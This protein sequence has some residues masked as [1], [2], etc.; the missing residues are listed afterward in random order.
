[1]GISAISAQRPQ[2]SMGQNPAVDSKIQA[3]E[4]KRDE[5]KKEKR[6]AKQAKQYEAAQKLERQIQKVQ[7][8]IEQLQATQDKQEKKAQDVAGERQVPKDPTM[9][10]YL[11]AYA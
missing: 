10:Q 1:M 8:Q 5:L 3:L 9:G 6:E 11:D 2:V 4:Q 7:K